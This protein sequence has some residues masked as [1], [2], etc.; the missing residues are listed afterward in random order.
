MSGRETAD[1]ALH[2][3]RLQCIACKL[4]HTVSSRLIAIHTRS[5]PTALSDV[6]FVPNATELFS[7]LAA[8]KASLQAAAHD[9]IVAGLR[10]KP[11]IC[12]NGLPLNTCLED[13]CKGHCGGGR[14]CIPDNC[15]GCSFK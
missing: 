8:A 9:A 1:R 10:M 2:E 5:T 7:T 13:P 12:S 4:P 15:G 6:R 3:Q 11:V 14:V